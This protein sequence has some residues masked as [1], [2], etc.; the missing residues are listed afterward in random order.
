MSPLLADVTAELDRTEY[1]VSE[2][3]SEVF[4]VCINITEQFERG[5]NITVVTHDIA[6]SSKYFG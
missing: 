6:A 1:S 5:L 2:D 3:I 4:E